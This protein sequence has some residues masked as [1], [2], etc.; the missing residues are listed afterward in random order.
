[1]NYIF[2]ESADLGFSDGHFN[3]GS[4]LLVPAISETDA[5]K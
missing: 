3:Y 5:N 1:M 4:L 2:I